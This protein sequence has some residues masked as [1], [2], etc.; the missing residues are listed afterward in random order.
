MPNKISITHD[1]SDQ[2]LADIMTTAVESGGHALWYWEGFSMTEVVRA[3]SSDPDADSTTKVDVMVGGDGEHEHGTSLS[4]LS[5]Y[6]L[7]FKCD[8][9][10]EG[11]EYTVDLEDI[12]QGMQWI[13][14]G[15]VPLNDRIT[16]MLTM[17]IIDRQADIDAD[18]ADCIIQAAC[19]KEYVFA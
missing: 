9:P 18:G 16:G 11:D 17:A 19:F 14:D 7:V 1:V 2:F 3:V 8:N 6:R 5:V 10:Q 15:T 12:A 13:L 4:N